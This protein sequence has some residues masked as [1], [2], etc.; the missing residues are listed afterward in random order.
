MP[1]ENHSRVRVK[2]LR[3]SG[4]SAPDEPG[5]WTG[6]GEPDGGQPVAAADAAGPEVVGREPEPPVGREDEDDAMALGGSARHGAGRE[7]GLVVR[8]GVE[9]HERARHRAHPDAWQAGRS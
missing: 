6:L 8:V 2:N 9:G 7:E 3:P 5:G 4:V 1:D